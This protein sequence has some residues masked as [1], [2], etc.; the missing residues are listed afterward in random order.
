M[1][2]YR[3]S[4]SAGSVKRGL[5]ANVLP[6]TTDKTGWATLKAM[7]DSAINFTNDSPRTSPDDWADAIAHRGLPL[8]VQSA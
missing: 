7:P 8:P 3:G 5:K 4:P 6:G 1:N 2:T